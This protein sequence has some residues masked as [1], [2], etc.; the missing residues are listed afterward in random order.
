VT[1]PGCAA[2]E[3]RIL[4]IEARLAGLT[5]IE[6][7]LLTKPTIAAIVA[8]ASTILGYP[9]ADILARGRVKELGDARRAVAWAARHGT[10]YPL[11]RIGEA[12]GDRDHTTIRAL[13]ACADRRRREDGPFKLL[14]DLL[15]NNARDRRSAELIGISR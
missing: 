12:L 15:L 13:V 10:R 1:C 2:L 5:P 6:R 7:S 3:A 11:A 14:S 9:A 8:D 4:D